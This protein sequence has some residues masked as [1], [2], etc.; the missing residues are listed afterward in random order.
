MT[1]VRSVVATVSSDAHTWNLVFLQLLLEERGHVVHN[2][3][4]CVTA[5]EV[6]ARCRAHGADL[7]VLSTVNGHGVIEAPDYLTEIRADAGL[8]RMRVVLGGNLSTNGKL[9]LGDVS[10]LHSSGFDAVFTSP[11]ALDEFAAFLAPLEAKP[12]GLP[13]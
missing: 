6:A 2:T 13:G 7:L 3:G 5:A 4:P 11:T 8:E 9:D 10:R 12:A 1:A